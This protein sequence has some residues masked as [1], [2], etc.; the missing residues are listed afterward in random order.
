MYKSEDNTEIMDRKK[1][2][3][4]IK[5]KISQVQQMLLDKNKAYGNS[6]LEPLHIFNKGD[7]SDSLCARIDYRLA[8]IKNAGL[9]DNTEDTLFDPCGYLI[10][11]MVA[12]D[13][14]KTTQ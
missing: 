8:R 13:K 4:E 10:L 12:N 3:I 7:A 5:L 1:R 6:A 14:I 2:E 9:N 11:L